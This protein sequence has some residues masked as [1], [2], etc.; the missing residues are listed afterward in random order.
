MCEVSTSQ[1][2][3]SPCHSSL[4]HRTWG[5]RWQFHIKNVAQLTGTVYYQQTYQSPATAHDLSQ[6]NDWQN[7]KTRFLADI[8]CQTCSVHC[9]CKQTV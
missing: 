2:V 1:D 5:H 6:S 8:S 3:R 9:K 7:G 4:C